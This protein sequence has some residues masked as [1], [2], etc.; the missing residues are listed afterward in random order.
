MTGPN[1]LSAQA[2]SSSPKGS[3][4]A[5]YMAAY[6]TWLGVEPYP[7]VSLSK[8]PKTAG[9]DLDM[10]KDVELVVLALKGNALSCR[11]L[12]KEHALTLRPSG[13]CETMPGEIITVS[14][15]RKWRYG[16]HPY[17]AGEIKA[18]RTDIPALGLTPLKLHEMGMWD[19]KEHYWGEPDEPMEP[20]AKPI[21]K[22]G[23]RPEYEMEQVLPGEDHRS[24]NPALR[25]ALAHRAPTV[26]VGI[27]FLAAS[28]FVGLRLGSEFL[29]HL[30][31]GNF[32]IRASMPMTLSLPDGEAA[33]RKM[34]LI[35]LNIRK[36][37]PSSPS[38][39]GPITAATPRPSRMS[40]CSCRSS[41]TTNGRKV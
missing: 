34:R 18:S 29:P 21:I 12:G 36:S 28:A 32:W 9:D 3:K 15:R 41:R 25:F 22:R 31:E 8:K 19:P 33:T 35:L 20:W 6:R 11:I 40:N 37:L 5:D 1:I 38:M 16:G 4:G 14:P 27:L 26:G 10:T 23:P 2:I 30:E 7:Q 39:A 17:L 24:Y 13:A